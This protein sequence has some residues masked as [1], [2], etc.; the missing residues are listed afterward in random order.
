MIK[1]FNKVV[2]AL[3]GGDISQKNNV[4]TYTENSIIKI[5]GDKIAESSIGGIWTEIYELGDYEFLDIHVVGSQSYKTFHGGELL[6]FYQGN[7]IAT[8][9][10][11]TKEIESTYS[12][13]SKRYLTTVS[14]DITEK[15]LDFLFDRESEN[16]FFK[17]N[18]KEEQFETI[19]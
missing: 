15:K 7:E 9:I 8:L 5:P 4:D 12:N 13:V 17:C 14:F 18:K 2:V 6:F 11:D 3:G 1:I 19:K 10:S 16:I